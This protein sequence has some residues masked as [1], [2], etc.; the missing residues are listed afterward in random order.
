[1]IHA[2]VIA[3]CQNT[4]QHKRM[5]IYI[6]WR[7]RCCRDLFLLIWTC[8]LRLPFTFYL[9]SQQDEMTDLKDILSKTFMTWNVVFIIVLVTYSFNNTWLEGLPILSITSVKLHLAATI[10]IN[11][12]VFSHKSKYVVLSIE[13]HDSS[14]MTAFKI[15]FIL[16]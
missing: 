16:D 7:N 8:L 1:M 15:I 10:H 5:K 9:F 14:T 11:F 2:N 13:R 12:I 4:V 6:F 3:G